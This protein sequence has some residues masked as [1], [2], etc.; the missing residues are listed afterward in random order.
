MKLPLALLVSALA[1]ATAGSMVF[2]ATWVWGEVDWFDSSTLWLWLTGVWWGFW[3]SL[4]GV[5]LIGLPVHAAFLSKRATTLRDYMIAGLLLGG[6]VLLPFQRHDILWLW[7][8][9][10]GAGGMTAGWCFWHSV[11]PDRGAI[12]PPSTS[13]G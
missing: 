6:G 9:T 10:G 1:A 8:S 5:V 3:L 7:I 2:T 13:A 4:I 12:S 11:R